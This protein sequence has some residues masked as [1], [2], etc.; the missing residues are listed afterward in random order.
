MAL[1]P[2]RQAEGGTALAA[3]LRLNGVLSATLAMLP[4]WTSLFSSP[5]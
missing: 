1:R 3:R 5:M 2:R 4:S